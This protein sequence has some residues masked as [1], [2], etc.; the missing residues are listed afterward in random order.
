VPVGA[1]PTLPPDGFPAVSVSTNAITVTL[2][3][4]DTVVAVVGNV[5]AAAGAT[6]TDVVVGA[7]FTVSATAAAVLLA[8]RPALADGVKEAVKLCGPTVRGGVRMPS[9]LIPV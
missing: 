7:A 1:A 3:P 8:L 2:V 6:K 5:T 4:E 9:T